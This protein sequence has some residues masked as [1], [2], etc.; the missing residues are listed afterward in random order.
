VSLNIRPFRDRDSPE[1]AEWLDKL[2]PADDVYTAAY[3]IHERRVPP[4]RERP[5]WLVAVLNGEPVGLGRDEP[6]VFG[7]RPGLRR[8]WVGVRPD[9]RRRGIGTRL[10]EEVENHARA[11]GGHTLRS[12]VALDQPDGER[13]LRAR[14]FAPARRELQSWVDPTSIDAAVLAQRRAA[15][16]VRGFR[17]A[18]LRDLLPGMEPLL[19]RLFV[20][21]HEGSPSD[22]PARPVSRSTFHRAILAN[23]TFDQDLSIV[24]L[25]GV[26]P[27]A[28]CWLKG[29]LG[30]G[31][32]GV[33]FT[34]TAPGW[35]GQGLATLAKLAALELAARAG[36]RWVGTANDE[37]D[38]AM[39]A[40]NRRLGHRPLPGLVI[41][42]RAITPIQQVRE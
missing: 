28:L 38:G 15:A 25:N 13:F 18:I 29:D 10:W 2:A 33:E 21:R 9:C 3:L 19:W 23:P 20:E 31:R 17:V 42:E 40:V 37:K 4:R 7:G 22:V 41:Y 32:H 35:R 6:Q 12:W 16:G 24:V 11:V 14:G 27:V 1:L 30:R 8:T 39:L 36:V 26:Q 5:V 34:A